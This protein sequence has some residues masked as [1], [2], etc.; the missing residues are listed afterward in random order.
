MELRLEIS[1]KLTLLWKIIGQCFTTT[2]PQHIGVL[3]MVRKYAAG[4]WGKVVYL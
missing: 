4:V 3:R 2:V 1:G